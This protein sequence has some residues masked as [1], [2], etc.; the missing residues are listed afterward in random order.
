MAPLRIE[1][2]FESPGFR[3][4]NRLIGIAGLLLVGC[5]IFFIRSDQRLVGTGEVKNRDEYIFYSP[6]DV[7]IIEL[8][9]DD[10]ATVAEGEV[11]LRLESEA[12]L[13]RI[14]DARQQL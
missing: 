10:G 6:S 2:N 11:L 7:R 1:E 12:L 5:G 14:H 4:T 3:K 13:E 8:F 9:E